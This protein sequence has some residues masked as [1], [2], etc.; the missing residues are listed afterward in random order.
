[1]SV[2]PYTA[3]EIVAAFKRITCKAADARTSMRPN[4]F[5][6]RCT[7]LLSRSITVDT[8]VYL[9]KPTSMEECYQVIANGTNGT[10]GVHTSSWEI[11]NMALKYLTHVYGS[12]PHDEDDDCVIWEVCAPGNCGKCRMTEYCHCD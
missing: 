12:K 9:Y 7:L 8:S 11:Y 5:D 1:M 3:D 4:P 2:I 10:T 6:Q